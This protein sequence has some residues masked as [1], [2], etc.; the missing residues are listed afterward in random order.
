MLNNR[1]FGKGTHTQGG[2]NFLDLSPWCRM[3]GVLICCLI[4]AITP[5][6]LLWVFSL[7][8]SGFP[9]FPLAIG[10]AM[11]IHVRKRSRSQ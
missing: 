5:M 3:R 11:A 8:S 10:V 7:M 6:L 4:Y 2:G 1:G 9:V